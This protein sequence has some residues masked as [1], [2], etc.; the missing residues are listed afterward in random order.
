MMMKMMT[1]A[2]QE[3]VNKRRPVEI[4]YDDLQGGKDVTHLVEKAFGLN[5]LGMYIHTC[6]YTYVI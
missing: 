4:H 1:S 3:R 5:G 2:K 6:I